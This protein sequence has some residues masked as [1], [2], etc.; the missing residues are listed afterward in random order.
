MV[1]RECIYVGLMA[2][3]HQDWKWTLRA[4]MLFPVIQVAIWSFMLSQDLLQEAEKTRKLIDNLETHSDIPLAHDSGP[5][6]LS[7]ELP[8]HFGLGRTKKCFLFR[9]ILPMYTL[10][11]IVAVS[12]SMVATTG[13]A[14]TY[15]YLDSFK[16]A[17]KGDLNWQLDCSYM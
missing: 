10:P 8:K 9:T 4:V 13:L 5:T 12:G 1:V 7:T 16:L 11:L 14:S 2:L 3:F 6:V 17:P 15:N